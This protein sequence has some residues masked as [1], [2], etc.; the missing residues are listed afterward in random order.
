MTLHV[1]VPENDHQSWWPGS[2]REPL[3]LDLFQLNVRNDGVAKLRNLRGVDKDLTWT[4][5]FRKA[6]RWPPGSYQIS[7][8]CPLGGAYGPTVPIQYRLAERSLQAY[9]EDAA[10]GEMVR[11]IYILDWFSDEERTKLRGENPDWWHNVFETQF[12]LAE[13]EGRISDVEHW[14]LKLERWPPSRIESK[15]SSFASL[16]RFISKVSLCK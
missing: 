11:H 16:R 1:V 10:L 8:P 12:H 9:L 7:R 15:A 3:I 14:T 13:K 5:N 4:A 2:W 6:F